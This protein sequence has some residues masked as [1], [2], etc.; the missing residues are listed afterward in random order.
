[1]LIQMTT[2][3]INHD[4]EERFW[5]IFTTSF[6]INNYSCTHQNLSVPN[7]TYKLAACWGSGKGWWDIGIPEQLIWVWH[8]TDWK[9]WQK[10]SLYK[11]WIKYYISFNLR[12]W[13]TQRYQRAERFF[14]KE[15]IEINTPTMIQTENSF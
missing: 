6:R 4:C 2:P 3:I 13:I 9:S 12:S 8:S 15:Y 7:S 11:L 14:F 1:M 10:I 5:N